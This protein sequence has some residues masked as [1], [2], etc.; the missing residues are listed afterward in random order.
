M[1]KISSI[2]CIILLLIVSNISFIATGF[3]DGILNTIYV[4]DDNI[5]GPWDGSIEHPFRFIQ[6]AI[7]FS[8]DE[9]KIIVFS[10]IYSEDIIIKKSI[11]I[12]GENS[13]KTI[14]DA[15]S[16]NY[17]IYIRSPGGVI[18][19]IRVNIS[20]FT[21]QDTDYPFSGIYIKKSSVYVKNC[22]F[23]NNEYNGIHMEDN[24]NNSVISSEFYN[25]GIGINIDESNG[26]FVSKNL[27]NSEFG[28]YINSDENTITDNIF[29]QCGID[30][31]STCNNNTISNNTVNNKPLIFLDEKNNWTIENAGQII[32][33]DCKNIAIQN[34]DVT[35]ASIGI[36]LFYSEDCI[37]DSNDLS[38]NYDGITMMYSHHNYIETNKMNNILLR[39][40]YA[41]VSHY[42]TFEKNAIA[43]FMDSGILLYYSWINEI[44]HNFIKSHY[45]S[46]GIY[47]DYSSYN[48]LENNTISSCFRGIYQHLWCNHTYVINNTMES[49]IY[50]GLG[51]WNCSYITFSNNDISKSRQAIEISDSDNI[52]IEH[53]LILN[54]EWGIQSYSTL[55]FEISNNLIKNNSHVGILSDSS[56]GMISNNIFNNNWDD[57]FIMGPYQVE[58]RKNDFINHNI[59]LHFVRMNNKPDLIQWNGNYWD[60]WQMNLPRPILG[61]RFLPIN[62]P[63]PLPVFK[64]DL[65]PSKVPF[66]NNEFEITN[67]TVYLSSHPSKQILESIIPNIS[68]RKII[69]SNGLV[70]NSLIDD[71]HKI[72]S[73]NE[74]H[75]E[76]EFVFSFLSNTHNEDTAIQ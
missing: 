56:G 31:S 59:N 42:N 14:I 29:I 4:D 75:N 7:D 2:V 40:I 66:N 38:N 63:I 70:E 44:Q 12:E 20:G 51:L 39:G 32:L 48:H 22:I 41:Y 13:E 36:Q 16:D 19:D 33:Y 17:G 55:N 76:L 52:L 8:E 6:D 18:D 73:Y 10:G 28:I 24:R 61:M 27:F 23:K 1:K 74:T 11:I 71:K 35:N 37:V 25:N 53:N 68:D 67:K 58:I 5:E 21:I 34:N 3:E 62:I 69:E 26:N 49:C 43:D 60:N 30:Y 72:I 15:S 65:N 45:Q 54:N 47:I 50:S 57:T 46:S 64:F 9:D